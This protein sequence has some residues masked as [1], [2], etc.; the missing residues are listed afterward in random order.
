MDIPLARTRLDTT[1]A[2]LL[3]VYAALLTA[4]VLVTS[5]LLDDVALLVVLLVLAGAWIVHVG[6]FLTAW[7]LLR[8]VPFP[9]GVHGDGVH[10]RTPPGE[11]VVPWDAVRSATLH[12]R[13]L[14][15]PLLRVD[16]LDPDQRPV[17]WSLR[18]LDVSPDV[19]RQAFTVHSGGRVQLR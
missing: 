10:D 16:L 14:R 11:V 3:V 15:S 13:L 8:K 12:R 19:L 1:A 7:R 18:I 17:R 2:F 6:L 5:A 4:I 9:L